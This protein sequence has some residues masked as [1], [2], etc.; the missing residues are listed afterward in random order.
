M[1]RWDSRGM[2]VSLADSWR[3]GGLEESLGG[4]KLLL[5]G[6]LCEMLLNGLR[7]R[8]GYSLGRFGPIWVDFPSLKRSGTILNNLNHA[9]RC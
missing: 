4:A 9:Q 2:R 3:P 7:I 5:L 1:V 6:T 8:Q